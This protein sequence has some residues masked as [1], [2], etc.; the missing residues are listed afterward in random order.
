MKISS[1]ICEYNPFHNG[2][3]YMLDKMRQNGADY[4]IAC[5]SGNFTQRGDFAVFDKYSRT[6]TALQN[7]ID[8]VIELPVTFSCAAAEKFAYG[9]VSLLHS[10]GCIDTIYFGSECGNTQPLKHTA[11]ILQSPEISHQL[12][13]YLSL[14]QTF[15]QARQNAILDI[16]PH[17]GD[18]LSYPNNI[19][20]V[21]YIKALHE[22]HSP[23]SPCTIQRIGSAHDSL[24]AVDNIAS[25][26]LIRQM[27]Y[28][29][30]TNF[31][32]YIPSPIS[33]PV[34]QFNRLETAVLYKLRMMSREDFS[35]LPDI[36]EGLEH[37]LYN[38][39][40]NGNSVQEI[41]SLAKTKRYTM[42]RL[43]R[44]IMYG[45]LGISKNDTAI[46]PQYIKILGFTQNGRH[47]LRTMRETAKLPVIMR[48]ADT[49]KLSETAQYLYSLESRCDDIYALSG[50]T[51]QKCGRNLTTNPVIL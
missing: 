16:F 5:M 10:L 17:L 12:K 11:N 48:Y 44:L 37:R 4:I 29:N 25:A 41:L 49:K 22:L 45:F 27:I 36:S 30:N 21:E 50:I 15:A 13:K 3:K 18:I 8:L 39:V 47:I 24:T 6:R 35:N 1:L 33:A 43:K 26:T 9:G 32:K 42:S 23:I 38:A 31:Q 40:R 19:L 7:G 46:P 14:G 20:A 28:E 2:H 51:P 34:H